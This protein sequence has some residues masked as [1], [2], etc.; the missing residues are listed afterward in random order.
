M[1]PPPFVDSRTL[2][3]RA[4]I[5]KPWNIHH[6]TAVKWRALAHAGAKFV[7]GSHYFMVKSVLR[8]MSNDFDHELITIFELKETSFNSLQPGPR[9]RAVYWWFNNKLSRHT[10]RECRFPK[11]ELSDQLTTGPHNSRTNLFRLNKVRTNKV[12]DLFSFG[13]FT[14]L[15]VLTRSGVRSF[16]VWAKSNVW[17]TSLIS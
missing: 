1:L 8:N 17:K 6:Y 16:T 15:T 7:L 3:I 4:K 12:P 9:F 13:K 14:I 11:V 5:R 2:P 10:E